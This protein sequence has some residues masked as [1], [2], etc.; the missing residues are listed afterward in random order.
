MVQV[1]IIYKA[2]DRLVHLNLVLEQGSTVSE[3][4]DKSGLY[5]QYPETRN[6]QVG[7][8]SKIVPLDTIL[9]SGDRIEIYKPLLIDPKEKRRERAKRSR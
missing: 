5:Q 8:F 9:Q 6:L 7:I 4:L 2:L 1:E 3:A